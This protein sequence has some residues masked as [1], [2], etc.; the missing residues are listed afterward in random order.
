MQIEVGPLQLRHFSDVEHEGMVVEIAAGED[1]LADVFREDGRLVL[2]W[3]IDAGKA[4]TI[5]LELAIKALHRAGEEVG[6]CES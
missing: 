5:P 2:R 6:S 1:D 3:Y 4:V